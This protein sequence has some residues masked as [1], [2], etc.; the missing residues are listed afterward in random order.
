MA[1]ACYILQQYLHVEAYCI[2]VY[3]ILIS[4][5]IIY[6][7]SCAMPMVTLNSHKQHC[8]VHA[9]PFPQLPPPPPP[10]PPTGYVTVGII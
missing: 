1:M 10:P 3:C 5:I 6:G 7:Y 2:I 9:H 4:G 8:I